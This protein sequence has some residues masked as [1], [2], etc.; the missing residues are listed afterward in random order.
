MQPSLYPHPDRPTTVVRS[1]S[2]P[3]AAVLAMAFACW[4]TTPAK[5]HPHVWIDGDATFV[6]VEGSLE[7]ID[8]VWEVDEMISLLLIEDFDVDRTG[9]FSAEQV[10]ALWDGSFSGLAEFNYFVNL[11]IDGEAYGIP[12][13]ERFDADI[14]DGHV[15]Y[16][17]RIP[18]SAPVDPREVP[19]LVGFY[20]ETFFVEVTVP[21]D[22]IEFAGTGI[23]ACEL[24]FFN[25]TENPI[26]FG[27]VDPPM[28][29]LGCS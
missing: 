24:R 10:A 22:R 14:D 12:D 21:E 18:M 29:D 19:V 8:I 26:Y 23:P 4:G 7:A 17:F 5:A 20:D 25:D 6:F 13:I 28:V 2:G 3:L 27:Y 9:T 11:R 16:S 1:F 15:V